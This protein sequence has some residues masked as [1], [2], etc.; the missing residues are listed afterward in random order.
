LCSVETESSDQ[1]GSAAVAEQ[2][3]NH[4]PLRCLEVPDCVGCLRSIHTVGR[5][6]VEPEHRQQVLKVANLASGRT[7]GEQ[8]AGRLDSAGVSRC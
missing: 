3:V 5:A 8:A 4:Q 6:R 2:P 1:G 7:G